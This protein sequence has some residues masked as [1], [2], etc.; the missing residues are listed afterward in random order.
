[1]DTKLTTTSP[2]ETARWGREIGQSLSGGE[3]L[4]LVGELGSGKTAFVKGLAAGLGVEQPVKSP[5]YTYL[6]EYQLPLRSTKL[7]HFDLYRLPERPSSRDLETVELL[8]RLADQDTITVIE[9]GDR[10]S[11]EYAGGA[12][13]LAFAMAGEH[14]RVIT[15]PKKLLGARTR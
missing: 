15:V 12:Y 3:N 10:V 6:Q 13:R 8:E 4:L 1:M 9:W 7:A 14:R 11:H 2:E 5:T